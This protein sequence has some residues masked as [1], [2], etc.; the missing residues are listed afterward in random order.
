MTE[1]LW[2]DRSPFTQREVQIKDD[3]TGK[4]ENASKQSNRDTR[5]KTLSR[6]GVCVSVRGRL[7]PEA[8]SSPANPS[9]EFC[10]P[11]LPVE[12]LL[13]YSVICTSTIPETP[14][15]WIL[16]WACSVI[17][18][19]FPLSRGLAGV[20]WRWR[21]SIF[22][23]QKRRR[24]TKLFYWRLPWIMYLIMCSAKGSLKRWSSRGTSLSRG[25][26]G[27]TLAGCFDI[28]LHC[29]LGVH[30]RWSQL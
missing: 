21:E 25:S 15:T 28:Y 17:M 10:S 29:H 27:E 5:Q 20:Y 12:P 19:S 26:N 3:E 18:R 6:S 9:W 23:T 8:S 1:T 2:A 16:I 22:G 24:T 30:L 7:V 13:P 4:Q 14:I 11:A